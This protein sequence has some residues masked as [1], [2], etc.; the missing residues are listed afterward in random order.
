M[1]D[2]SVKVK[3]KDGREEVF[4][5]YADSQIAFE[6][7]AKMSISAAFDPNIKPKMESLYYLAWLAEKNSGVVV[8]TFDEWIK[9]I[10]S[11]GHEE[12]PGN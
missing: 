7:W 2:I 3:R 12:G 8:K 4:P 5:V 11:V 1:I 6:R 9:D 10:A